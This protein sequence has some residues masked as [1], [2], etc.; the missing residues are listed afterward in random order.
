MNELKDGYNSMWIRFFHQNYMCPCKICK[1]FGEVEYV[2]NNAIAI[3]VKNLCD[4]I[5]CLKEE[6]DE[7]HNLQC[8]QGDCSTCTILAL[9]I[10]PCEIDVSVEVI[11]PWQWF[12]KIWVGRFDDGKDRHA[13]HLKHKQTLPHVLIT[14]LKPKL[15]EFVVHN[16][17]AKQ[18]DN[19]FGK[20]NY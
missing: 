13:L 6:I 14:F 3:H 12:E 8:S 5:L 7:F 9:P 4:Q 11:A 19:M 10:C 20:S 17:K 15:V 1:P 2:A 18:Q 16:F